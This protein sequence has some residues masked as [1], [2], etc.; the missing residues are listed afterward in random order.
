[1]QFEKLLIYCITIKKY[2]DNHN[3]ELLKELDVD[4]KK[5]FIMILFD[6]QMTI[7]NLNFDSSSK[8]IV[9]NVFKT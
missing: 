4:G 1:M 2:I 7:N 5:L 6:F 9:S 3:Q 8:D